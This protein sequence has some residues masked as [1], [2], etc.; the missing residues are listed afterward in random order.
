M[1]WDPGYARFG[2]CCLHVSQKVELEDYGCLSTDS[3]DS[4][5]RRLLILGNDLTYLLDTFQPDVIAC[6]RSF[7][8]GQANGLEVAQ[9]RGMALYLIA[10]RRIPVV[11]YAPTTVKLHISGSGA[12]KKP[13]VIQGVEQEFGIDLSG[14]PDDCADAIRRRLQGGI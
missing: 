3:T 2:F 12:A 4:Y 10:R 1:S 7:F 8:S 14:F 11:P 6:E 5:M 9:A 13:D